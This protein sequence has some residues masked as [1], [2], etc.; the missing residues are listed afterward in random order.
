[1][2]S[3]AADVLAGEPLGLQLEDRVALLGEQVA[4]PAEGLAGL[5]DLARR[6]EV[7][8]ELAGMV[9]V[10]PDRLL[11][12]HVLL[13]AGGPAILVDDLVLRRPRQEGDQM[14]RILEFGRS[15]PDFAEEAPP[16]ALEEVERVEPRPQEP[17]QLPAH[18]QA[19]LGLVPLQE[20][21]RGLLVARLDPGEETTDVALLVEGHIHNR[22]RRA[23]FPCRAE[24]PIHRPRLRRSD[25]CA[26]RAYTDA[27]RLGKSFSPGGASRMSR[28]DAPRTFLTCGGPATMDRSA[29]PRASNPRFEPRD[30][31]LRAWQ[32]SP[33]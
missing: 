32:A 20:L 19:D 24:L 31:A 21:T 25:R 10:P 4:E 22:H 16:D 18:H 29:T 28:A 33:P 6:V 14:P 5:G 11:A 23:S 8:G 3:F 15:G 2:P 26:P 1:M 9:A 7:G 30:P 27:P 17:G 12:V 13:A